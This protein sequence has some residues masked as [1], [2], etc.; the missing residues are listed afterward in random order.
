MSKK[1]IEIIIFLRLV[2]SALLHIKASNCK[3][4]KTSVP[5]VRQ[6]Q[7]KNNTGHSPKRQNEESIKNKNK[8]RNSTH[9]GWS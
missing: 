2:F 9:I 6:V 5:L 1:K 3:D 8:H 7:Q 4:E